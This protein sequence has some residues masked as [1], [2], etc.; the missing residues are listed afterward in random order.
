M[1][2]RDWLMGSYISIDIG[3]TAIKFAL[4]SRTGDILQHGE[5]ATQASQGGRSIVNKVKNLVERFRAIHTLRG[6][7]IST[8]GMVDYKKGE[9]FFAGPQIP[10]YTGVNWKN[11]MEAA[12]GLPCEVENDV[13]CA[14]L[15]EALSGAGRGSAVSLC[16][17]IGT[18]IGGCA[19]M[20]GKVY[21]GFSDSACEVGHMHISDGIFQDLASTTALV[22]R[23]EERSG[24]KKNGKEIFQLARQGTDSVCVEEIDRQMSY[25]AE[26]ISN[27][28]YVLNPQTVILGGGIMG[29]WDYLEPRL[30]AAAKRFMLPA[31]L[32]KTRLTAA[33]HK[34][35]AGVLGAFYHFKQQRP[36]EGVD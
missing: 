5:M 19:V 35:L 15:A 30:L 18:G 31:L 25:L 12:F 11:E 17:T 33:A 34:N 4:L 24:R 2:G 9:I 22:R 6:V 14:G 10:D 26:G 23:V 13:N 20:D 29:D 21:H 32:E 36:Q 8:A 28:C 3:G 7:C 27:I 1:K 16:L